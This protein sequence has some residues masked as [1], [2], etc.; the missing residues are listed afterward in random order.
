MRRLF[1]EE[2]FVEQA[3]AG[4][5]QEVVV[6]SGTPSEDAQKALGL[7][8]GTKSQMLSY[9]DSNNLELAR[10]HRYLL[11]DG[12]LGASGK[13]DPKRVL[14]DGI[15]YRLERKKSEGSRD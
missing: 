14:K 9:R 15:L 6:H 3:L 4:H 10:A 5:M 7:P 8:P 12:T 2:S 1:N 13:P 11:P